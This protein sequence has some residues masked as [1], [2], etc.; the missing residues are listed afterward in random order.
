M[1]AVAEAFGASF[2]CVPTTL[3]RQPRFSACSNS[4]NNSYADEIGFCFF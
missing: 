3:G 1:Q 2:V 4:W